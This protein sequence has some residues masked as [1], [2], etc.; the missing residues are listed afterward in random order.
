MHRGA[1]ILGLIIAT[2]AVIAVFVWSAVWNER[3][4]KPLTVSFL[5]VG[6]GDAIFIT[7][8]SGEQVLIDGGPDTSV[9]RQLG[10]VMPWYDHSIDMVVATH[11]DADHITGLI[12]V[13]ERYT[14]VDM[15]QSSVQGTTQTWHMLEDTA[16]Q[17]GVTEYTAHRGERID[18]G[19]GAYLDVLWPDRD[20]PHADTNYACVVTRLVYGSTSFLFPCDAP[21]A[22]EKELVRL[23]GN[24]LHSDVLK[25]GHHGSKT[26]SSELFIGYVNP[27]Y[28]VFSRGCKNKYGFPSPQTVDTMKKFDIPTLDTC[29]DGTITFASDGE[30]VVRK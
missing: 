2:L 19:D 18:L 4:G 16:T 1:K 12:D 3:I 23:G 10:S 14:V 13:L 26:S 11:P 8:P 21:Q 22:V 15:L 30:K 24:N 27:S 28:V 9:V 7:A 5:N 17:K 29:T 25:A 6:E 20:L